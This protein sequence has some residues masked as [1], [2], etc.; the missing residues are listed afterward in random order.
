MKILV[1][2]ATP[3]STS[4]A[5]EWMMRSRGDMS[6]FHEPFGEAW[7]LGEDALWPR[8]KSDSPRTKGLT[9]DSVWQDLQA[10]AVKGPVFSKEFPH[11]TDHMWT[12]KF[13][14]HFNHSFL[15]RDP[16]KVAT[17]MYTNWPDFL[18]KEI[19][20]VE[21]RELFDRCCDDLGKVPPVIDSDD[22]L[23]N[24]QGIVKS[25]CNAVGIPYI[26]EAL[27]WKPIRRDEVL[28]YDGG[29]WHENVR[30]SDGLKTLPRDYIDISEAPDRVR[31]I[32]DI[33]L[34]HYQ[35]LYAHRL[36]TK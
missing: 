24:P 31:E 2:W 3:R 32:Y 14:S 26:K 20:F 35:H 16:A 13:L 33:I 1:L 27:S 17:S 5:F 12:D 28:W 25:Y 36:K 15:I 21:Q 8:I 7:H 23:K 34:P 6:C 18:L 29:S 11:Y 4:T 9:F 22:L 19:G 30:N 10:A